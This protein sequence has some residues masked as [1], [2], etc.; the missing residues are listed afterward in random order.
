[1]TDFFD[2]SEFQAH[3]DVILADLAKR[4]GAPGDSP[5]FIRERAAAK[6]FVGPDQE[7]FD[8]KTITLETLIASGLVATTITANGEPALLANCSTVKG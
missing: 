7:T 8:P 3:V 1:M 6:C 5:V 2:S 4:V